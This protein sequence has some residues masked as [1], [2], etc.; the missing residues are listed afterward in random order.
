MY[1]V[2]TDISVILVDDLA[3]TFEAQVDPILLRP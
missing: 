2:S 1:P 3:N